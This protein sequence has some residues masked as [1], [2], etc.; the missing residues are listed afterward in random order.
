[1]L[2]SD[3]W[4]Y[5]SYRPAAWGIRKSRWGHSTPVCVLNNTLAI[6]VRLEGNLDRRFAR[7]RYNAD[8]RV[9]SWDLIVGRCFVQ[10]IV[11]QNTFVVGVDISRD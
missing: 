1:V 11:E 2:A 7:R 6:V 10:P 5:Q 8:T 9:G 3:S 4:I